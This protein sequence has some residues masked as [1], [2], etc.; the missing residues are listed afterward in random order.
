MISD[1]GATNNKQEPNFDLIR[2]IAEQAN[3]PVC[4]GGG[5]SEIHQIERSYLWG[6][7]RFQF[8]QQYFQINISYQ[9][10]LKSLDRKALSQLN[11]K[12][13][14]ENY[15]VFVNGKRFNTGEDP[16]DLAKN[17]SSQGIGE[18]VINSI[19][20]DGCR[21]GYDAEL[22]R[23]LSNELSVPNSFR[24]MWINRSHERSIKDFKF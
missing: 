1:I 16:V 3:M 8:L 14:K 2:S 7:K 19:D 9:K 23:I 10:Q 17:L 11:V 24:W 4:Y 20:L 5:I 21:T 15:S 12:R 6:L 13:D 18:I 22:A